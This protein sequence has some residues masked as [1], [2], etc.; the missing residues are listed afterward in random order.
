[1]IPPQKD[2]KNKSIYI[3][4]LFFILISS[5]NNKNIVNE[6][7]FSNKLIFTIAGLPYVDNQKLIRDLIHTNKDNIFKIDEKKLL[8]KITK[9]NLVF[10]FFAKKKYPNEIEI[11]INKTAYVGKTYKNNKL[12][13]I[14]SN[15]KLIDY[16]VS[17]V[18]NIPYFYGNFT[19]NEF[20]KF[21]S[22]I[23]KIQLDT[24]NISSFYFFPSGRWD[25]KFKDNL[26]L[27][28]PNKN[29]NK[30][31]SEFLMF[32]N[33]QKFINSK[34]IDLRIKNRIISND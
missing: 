3:Y 28:L 19:R 5:I 24:K 29:L 16:D 22:V 34:I 4:I 21:L 7:L 32:K 13:L 10:N 18:K 12:Y 31:L 33:N 20:L 8:E 2:K 1:M 9:N 6:K 23:N 15:G 26:L 14:G 11:K 30:S 17:I 27:K 25:I